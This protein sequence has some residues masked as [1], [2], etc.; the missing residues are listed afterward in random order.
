M[1][2]EQSKLSSGRVKLLFLGAGGM[3]DESGR[4]WWHER[5]SGTGEGDRHGQALVDN[6]RQDGAFKA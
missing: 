4:C 6:A 5:E 3:R 2:E 1:W